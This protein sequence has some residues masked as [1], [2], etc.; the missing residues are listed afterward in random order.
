MTRDARQVG[1]VLV[2]L[3]L[4]S[5]LML[6][7]LFA[8]IELGR[9]LTEFKVLVGQAEAAARYLMVRPPGSGR[10]EAS[11][12]ARYGV[13]SNAA[14]CGGG[15]PVLLGLASA[16]ITVEDAV[17]TP[18]TRLLQRTVTTTTNEVLGVTVNLVQVK[19]TGYTH[20]L[21]GPLGLMNVFGNGTASI[22]LPTISSTQRQF[23]G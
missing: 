20:T 16:A 18:G 12:L 11:C 9:V 8:L 14:N 10:T 1:S 7:L 3:A 22:T 17:N 4:I 6:G 15:A 5:S 19:I 13:I 23:A 21:T 2:E